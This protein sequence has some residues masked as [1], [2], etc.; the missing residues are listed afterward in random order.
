MG[1]VGPR[2]VE[3]PRHPDVLL[4]SRPDSMAHRTTWGNR[5][6]DHDVSLP[7]DEPQRRM[8]HESAGFTAYLTQLERNAVSLSIAL[9][10][11]FS[12]LKPKSIQRHTR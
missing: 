2:S 5:G 9:L 4:N 11:H 6:L 7:P 10:A 1:W 8:P 3:V 12:E